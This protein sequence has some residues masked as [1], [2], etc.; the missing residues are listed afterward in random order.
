MVL[1]A[2]GAVDDGVDE[3]EPLG[4]E[5]DGDVVVAPEPLVEL[6]PVV[7]SVERV[8]SGERDGTVP[9][10]ADGVRSVVGRSPMRSLRDSLQPVISVAPR[11]RANTALSNFFIL[12]LPPVMALLAVP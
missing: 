2:G 3:D 9:G 7:V 5:S 4:L 8:V 1:D 10:D 11:A 6:E 12:E